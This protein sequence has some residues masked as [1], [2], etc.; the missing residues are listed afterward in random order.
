MGHSWKCFFPKCIPKVITKPRD[1]IK[2]SG[3][4]NITNQ[5]RLVLQRSLSWQWKVRERHIKHH[6]HKLGAQYSGI[7]EYGPTANCFAR[8]HGGAA[9]AHAT[10]GFDTGEWWLRLPRSCRRCATTWDRAPAAPSCSRP[11]VSTILANKPFAIV[12]YSL[13]VPLKYEYLAYK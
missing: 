4:N 12:W 10:K 2:D 9:R 5:S 8:A 6:C 1:Q 13:L 7:L 3:I 11:S